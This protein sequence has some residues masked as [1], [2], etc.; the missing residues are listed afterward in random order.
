MEKHQ[1]KGHELGTS[2]VHSVEE[3]LQVKV[4]V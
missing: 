2:P 4:C 3:E 1:D